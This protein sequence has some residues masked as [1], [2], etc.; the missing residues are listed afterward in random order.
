MDHEEAKRLNKLVTEAVV[1]EA[2]AAI[3][4]GPFG[5]KAKKVSSSIDH[6][7]RATVRC[8]GV[9][10][11][12]RFD[13]STGSRAWSSIR[14]APIV[15]K[16]T[17]SG[18]YNSDLRGTYKVDPMKP[19]YVSKRLFEKVSAFVEAKIAMIVLETE[20]T[21]QIAETHQNTV[22]ALR[23]AGYQVSDTHDSRG[24]AE[25]DNGFICWFETSLK[26]TSLSSLSIKPTCVK[27]YAVVDGVRVIE[28]VEARLR[29]IEG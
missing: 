8:R 24:H 6:G 11:E 17:V 13:T 28:E 25:G 2:V 9:L 16:V 20:R 1:A 12:L 14:R 15:D 19:P 7:L 4:A 21:D 26:T 3:K 29:T 22:E 18:G 23:E 27:N 5:S 10:I